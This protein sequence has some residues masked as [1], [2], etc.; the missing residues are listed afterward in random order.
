MYHQ[1]LEGDYLD[2]QIIFSNSF[3]TVSNTIHIHIHVQHRMQT[4]MIYNTTIWA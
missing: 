1:K 3:Q 2:L 4:L